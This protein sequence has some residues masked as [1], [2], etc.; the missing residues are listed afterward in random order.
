MPFTPT[1]ILA[2]VPIAALARGGLPFAALA[3]GSMVPDLPLFV[4]IVMGYQVTHSALGLLT[5]DLP[6]GVVGFVA[7]ECLFKG[8]LIAL[9]PVAVQRR[10]VGVARPGSEPTC[11][12]GFRVALAVVLGA[13]THLAWDSFTHGDRLGTRFFPSLNAAALTVGGSPLPYYKVLQYGCTVVGLPLLTALAV[14][15]LRRQVPEPLDRLPRLPPV[16]KVA[17][18]L[19]AAAI[20]AWPLRSSRLGRIYHPTGNWPGSSPGRAWPN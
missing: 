14:S 13:F 8:L 3:V 1:H 17:A 7:F 2:V 9:M 12:F 4:P 18:W 15:W 5:A 6:L 11:G 16:A 20:P 19:V 10:C